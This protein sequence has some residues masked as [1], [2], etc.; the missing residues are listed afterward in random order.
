MKKQSLLA[1]ITFVSIAQSTTNFCMQQPQ[2]ARSFATLYTVL[3]A[4]SWIYKA[5]VA[6]ITKLWAWLPSDDQVAEQ[7][8][9][10][11]VQAYAAQ[12]SLLTEAEAV[13]VQT[14][15]QRAEKA[16]RDFAIERHE[17]PFETILRNFAIE[18]HETPI[19]TIL[20]NLDS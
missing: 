13:A 16:E 2:S 6:L 3:H 12:A 18:R 8:H 4:A 20:R 9:A 10:E 7:L 5:P 14:R 15:I 11:V 1:I 17:S 19:D